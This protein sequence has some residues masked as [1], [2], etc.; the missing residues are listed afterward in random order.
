LPSIYAQ[1]LAMADDHL[2]HW[3]L[4]TSLSLPLEGEALVG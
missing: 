1:N 3:K 2:I 4:F